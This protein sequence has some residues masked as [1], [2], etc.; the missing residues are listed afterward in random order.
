MVVGARH[1]CFIAVG[2]TTDRRRQLYRW[3]IYLHHIL[4][5]WSKENQSVLG[6]VIGLGVAYLISKWLVFIYLA[7]TVGVASLIFP[8]FKKLISRLWIGLATALGFINSRI[9][10][11]LVYFL[12]VVPLGMISR[13]F[14]KDKLQLKKKQQE[15]DSYY[16]DR[17]HVYSAEDFENLW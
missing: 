17:K 7:V 13:L 9:I 4:M 15:G 11:S 5:S 14:S 16:T 3:S 10:L 12:L 8:S 6:F 2:R 1:F